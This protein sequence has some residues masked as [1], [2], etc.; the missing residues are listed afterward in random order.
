M[1]LNCPKVI[2]ENILFTSFFTCP[3]FLSFLLKLL[4]GC[5]M[6]KEEA[7]SMYSP[8]WLVVMLTAANC[9]GGELSSDT[10]LMASI[11][12]VQLVCA[13]R[14]VTVTVVLVSPNCRGRKRTFG[15]HGSHCFTFHPH[16]LHMML[17]VTSFRPPVSRGQLQSRITEVSFILDITFLGADGGPAKQFN[18]D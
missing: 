4:L 12:K 9:L 3:F 2:E 15:L 16:F 10:P 1:Y 7:P 17:K 11:S 6:A 18:K 8:A 5:E 14:S 13:R